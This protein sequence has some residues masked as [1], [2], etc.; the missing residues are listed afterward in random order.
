MNRL[1]FLKVM[2]NS[3]QET[4]VEVATPLV[5]DDLSKVKNEWIVL[6]GMRWHEIAISTSRLPTVSWIGKM[7]ILFFQESDRLRAYSGICRECHTTIHYQAFNE[8]IM[9]L[10]CSKE[11][12]VEEIEQEEILE[13]LHI[14]HESNKIYV[15]LP[16]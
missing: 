5:E 10:T 13:E 7:P 11:W 8:K 9:C 1:D 15:A 16:N 3:L 12:K 6:N 2:K 14:K 4:V